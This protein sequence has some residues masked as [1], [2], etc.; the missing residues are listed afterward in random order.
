MCH[1]YRYFTAPNTKYQ[2]VLCGRQFISMSP[3]EGADRE[4]RGGWA[5]GLASIFAAVKRIFI[6]W[7]VGSKS[8]HNTQELARLAY[9]LGFAIYLN[10]QHL[11]IIAWSYAL[12]AVITSKVLTFADIFWRRGIYICWNDFEVVLHC[13]YHLEIPRILI[14]EKIKF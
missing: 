4:Y 10:K 8:W 12:G 9:L 5:L 7:D 3:G 6:F 2:Y 11:I 1:F 13:E 14:I